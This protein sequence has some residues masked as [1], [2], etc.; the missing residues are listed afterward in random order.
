MTAVE[1]MEEAA[2]D[3][4]KLLPSTDNVSGFQNVGYDNGKFKAYVR[5]GG[6][7]VH[8]GRF[9]T[10]EEAAL[11]FARSA[12]GTRVV[13]RLAVGTLVV[14]PAEAPAGRH[15]G[16]PAVTRMLAVAPIV[17]KVRS[18]SPAGMTRPQTK[19]R[20]W[21]RPFGASGGKRKL[22]VCEKHAIDYALGDH[23]EFDSLIVAGEILI[24][25]HC[26]VEHALGTPAAPGKLLVD[27]DVFPPGAAVSAVC[28]MGSFF[29][30]V[31]S[32]SD[33]ASR[34]A[35]PFSLLRNECE[36]IGDD[37]AWFASFG[38]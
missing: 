25:D 3:G 13:G 20:R 26:L 36:D 28:S 12:D 35:S 6:R 24:A 8:L 21:R 10:P 23:V 7:Q 1:A 2:L 5:R 38:V 29:E 19:K 9:N 22:A 31:C 32:S 30:S 17:D 4:T 16:Q 37:C 15:M 11:C 34:P 18:A 33:S 27:T 14:K